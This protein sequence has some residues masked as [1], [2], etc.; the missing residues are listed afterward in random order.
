MTKSAVKQAPLWEEWLQFEMF[1]SPDL[2]SPCINKMDR[3]LPVSEY[4]W[5]WSLQQYPQHCRTQ[6]QTFYSCLEKKDLQKLFNYM[7]YPIS[8]PTCKYIS[9]CKKTS[10]FP[11]STIA[12]MFYLQKVFMSNLRKFPSSPAVSCTSSY[13]FPRISQP[14]GLSF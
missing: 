5:N 4:P 7:V 1:F 12:P 14:S 11:F 6:G 9:L 3:C 13:P 10:P 2:F 8:T